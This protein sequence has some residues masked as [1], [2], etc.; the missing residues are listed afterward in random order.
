MHIAIYGGSFNPPHLGHVAAARHVLAALAPDRLLVIPA[1]MPPHKAL[2][3]DSPCARERFRLA[4]LAFGQLPRTLVSDMELRRAGK[5]YSVD[6]LEALRAEQ[7][8]AALHLVMGSDMLLSMETWHEYRRI[9]ELATLVAFPR[10]AG[11]LPALRAQAAHLKKSYGARVLL[12][13][14]EPLPMHSTELR[15]ALHARGGLERL[16]KAVYAEI[17]RHR[18]YGARP[19]LAWLREQAHSFLP[20]LRIPH[21]AGCEA[22][23]ERLA[24][25]W[26]VPPAFAAEAGILHDITKKFKTDDQLRMCEK[27]GIMNDI[28]EIEHPKLLHA[29]TGAALARD[30]FG[31]SDEVYSAIRWHTVGRADMTLLEQILYMADYIEPTRVFEGVERLRAL[32]YEDLDAAMAAGLE[33]SR[34]EVLGK[35]AEP[36]PDAIAALAWFCAAK[37]PISE[38]DDET[39]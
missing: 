1:G 34:D 22:E 6:T 39:I 12:L 33:M 7:P 36:H 21:V 37:P 3:G 20:E 29:K 31:I 15:A 19:N 13:D 27:Y 24:A 17:I 14:V 11:E 2:K 8:D 5:S 18:L 16:P 30:L 26:G 23:A 28:V 4:Q 9:M 38:G 32:A 35:G 10:E 25:R